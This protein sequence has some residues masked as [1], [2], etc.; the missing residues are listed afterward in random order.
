ML[1]HA[2]SKPIKSK[3]LWILIIL[4]FNALGA[5]VYYFAVKREFN[6]NKDSV[7]AEKVEENQ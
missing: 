1:V 4:M 3:A 6:K 7:A 5:L 2:I